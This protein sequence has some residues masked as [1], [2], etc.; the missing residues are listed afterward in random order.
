MQKRPISAL[1]STQ[2]PPRLSEIGVGQVDAAAQA[3]EEVGGRQPVS[4]ERQ[5]EFLDFVGGPVV[6]A[7][8]IAQRIQGVREVGHLAGAHRAKE[9]AASPQ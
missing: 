2:S 7:V 5:D 9:A 6:A 1:A 8:L 4:I 3:P